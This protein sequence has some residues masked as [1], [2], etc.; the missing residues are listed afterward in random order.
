MDVGS[1]VEEHV[2]LCDG[3]ELLFPVLCVVLLLVVRRLFLL[4][5]GW[6]AE[7]VWSPLSTLHSESFQFK[8]LLNLHSFKYVASSTKLKVSGS[9]KISFFTETMMSLTL[10]YSGNENCI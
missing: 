9:L 10:V 8:K 7:I 6:I 5:L 2:L 1:K 3:W 4:K